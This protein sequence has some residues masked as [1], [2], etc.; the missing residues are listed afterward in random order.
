MQHLEDVQQFLEGLGHIKEA[1]EIGSAVET[2][3]ILKMKSS[4]QTTLHIDIII[5][6]CTIDSII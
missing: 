3:T 5:T 2:M 6:L 4:K 1:L